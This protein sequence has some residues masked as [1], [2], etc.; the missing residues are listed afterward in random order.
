MADEVSPTAALSNGANAMRRAPDGRW[1]ADDFD[2]EGFVRG[3]RAAGHEPA[4]R[5]V[6]LVGAGG[7][8]SAIAVSLLSAGAEL[9]ITDREE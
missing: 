4:G 9:T 2:G 6:W 8:G 5:H 3:L 7:A 1:Q